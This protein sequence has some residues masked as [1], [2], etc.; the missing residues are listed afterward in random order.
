MEQQLKKKKKSKEES[1]DRIQQLQSHFTETAWEIG[2]ELDNIKQQ[3]KHG[4]FEKIVEENFDFDLSYARRFRRIFL[5]FDSE[6]SSRFG[7]KKLVELLKIADKEE[8]GNFIEVELE[9]QVP[10]FK[11]LTHR[12]D[13]FKARDVTDVYP[14]NRDDQRVVDLDWKLKDILKDINT[15][16]NN[17]DTLNLMIESVK[18]YKGEKLN[19]YIR[20]D[21]IK[22][23][24]KDFNSK[25]LNKI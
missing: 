20:K 7:I 24:I 2:K 19:G 3:C 5:E 4:E 15:I 6:T 23:M 16:N 11:E 18:K 8:R 1:I 13:E 25:K 21:M 12:I 17:V 9:E 10:P 14:Q 22:E